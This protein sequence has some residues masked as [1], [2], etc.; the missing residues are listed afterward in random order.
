MK[1]NINL[2]LCLLSLAL[3]MSVTH[4]WAQPGC[5]DESL[6]DPTVLCPGLFEPVCGCDGNTYSNSCIATY[7]FG[8]TVWT[9]GPCSNADVTPPVLN[10]PGDVTI[11]CGSDVVLE[12]ATASD[13]SGSVTLTE[14][15]EE[16]AGSCGG[17]STLVRIFTAT[18]PSGNSTTGQQTINF[19]DTTAPEWTTPPA[20]AT[21]G[22]SDPM[23]AETAMFSWASS[24]AGALAFDDCSAVEYGND[25]D[26][27]PLI[28]CMETIYVTVGFYATD[29]C[30]N[31]TWSTA[32]L[33]IEPQTVEVEPCEN[34]A[35]VDFGLCDAILG[36]THLN[37]Y[38][39]EISGCGTT[40]G[41][42]DY[43]PAFYTTLE[44]CVNS[45]NE[46]CISQEYLDLGVMI[47][48]APNVDEVCGC[49][50][51][52]YQNACHAQYIGGNVT[53]QDGPCIV[54][55]FG[56][57]TYPAACNYN[58]Q[59]AFED[60]TCL[61]P[62]EHCPIPPGTAG[63]GCLYPDATNYDEGATWDNG[64]CTWIPCDSSC[65][66]DVNDDGAVTVSDILML[67]GQFGLVCP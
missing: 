42:V 45:C 6:I 46:G 10:V 24:M 2:H 40:V 36:Y 18:D 58:A 20:D 37:G 27:I 64:T 41:P 67:L 7:G 5:I 55:E 57:C 3:S 30:G 65:P 22:C 33:T 12:E 51:N 62:P 21:I 1:P 49:D 23:E 8:V 35:G 54:I 26:A 63:G 29:G 16:F 17:S 66:E 38:C 52:T 14:T 19:I 44:D 15:A 61:F 48:C 34:L 60:G 11:E 25:F 28:D 50:G 9:D 43:S 47:D 13:N 4:A 32:T 56:G 39:T 31:Q 53:W 59:A